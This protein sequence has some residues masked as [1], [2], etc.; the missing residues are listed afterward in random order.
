MTDSRY[1]LIGATIASAFPPYDD[2]VRTLYG[3]LE[4]QLGWRDECLQPQVATS[5]KLIRPRLCLLACRLV[6]GDERRALPVAA[7]VEIMHN[8]TLVHDDIQDQSTLRRGRPTVWHLWGA[9]QGITVGDALCAQSHRALYQLVDAGVPAELAL[10]IARHFDDTL[11]RIT[12]GQYLDVAFEDRL[13]LTE[14]DYLAMIERKTAA[15][16]AGA[17]AM[18]ALAG[19]GTLEAAQTLAAYGRALGLAYQ[20]QDDLLGIWGDPTVT[21]KPVH[22][23]L[24]RRKKSLPVVY[25]LAHAER[26]DHARLHAIYATRADINERDI[27]QLLAILKRVGAHHYAEQRAEH[28]HAAAIAALNEVAGGDHAAHMELRNVADSLQ[29]RAQ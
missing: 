7:A 28:Y 25:A 24:Y 12:E 14:A 6:G 1:S 20:I 3:M 11:L 23:D 2:Q 5:G 19:G 18:G 8:F 9:V 4:Y 17:L 21:G 15:L 27:E 16:I 26:E 10:H 22:D 13:D 29:R